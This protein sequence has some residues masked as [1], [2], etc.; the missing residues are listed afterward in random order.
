M[1]GCSTPEEKGNPYSQK[2]YFTFYKPTINVL[3]MRARPGLKSK[4]IRHLKKDDIMVIRARGKIETI[5][6]KKGQWVKVITLTNETG[7]CFDAYLEKYE[8]IFSDKLVPSY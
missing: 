1:F 8:D 2:D 5:N 3:R 7:W 4:F 6:G